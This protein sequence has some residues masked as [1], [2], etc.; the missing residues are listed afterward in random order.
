MMFFFEPVQNYST[1]KSL[2]AALLLEL[3]CRFEGLLVQGDD[4][5]VK[6]AVAL[7]E[8]AIIFDKED[9]RG[10]A[11]FID[12]SLDQLGG[13]GQI[14]AYPVSDADD[15]KLRPYFRIRYHRVVRTVSNQEAV[16]LAKWTKGG[17]K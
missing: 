16:A 15:A 2:K 17:A 6:I 12:H 5:P 11:I 10:R 4:A 8:Q 9:P 14:T 7:Q 3:A 13:S 1:H